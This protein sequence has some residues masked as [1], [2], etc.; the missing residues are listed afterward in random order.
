MGLYASLKVFGIQI[1]YMKHDEVDNDCNYY[2]LFEE[3][4]ETVMDEE[5]KRRVFEF[6]TNLENKQVEFKIYTNI[7]CTLETDG[8]NQY[9]DWWRISLEDF[10]RE[11]Q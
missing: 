2:I 9:M 10:L 4:Y 1:G 7:L 3:K 8:P 11:F 6:Y 5:Q